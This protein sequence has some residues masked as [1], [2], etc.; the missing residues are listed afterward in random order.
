M[1]DKI[2]KYTCEHCSQQHLSH[3][4]PHLNPDFALRFAEDR[5]YWRG[6]HDAMVKNEESKRYRGRTPSEQELLD[7]LDK[8]TIPV[9]ELREK[10][11]L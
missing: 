5:A 4:C 7:M 3:N 1:F 2:Y 9:K 6:Y 11:C 10:L 8:A